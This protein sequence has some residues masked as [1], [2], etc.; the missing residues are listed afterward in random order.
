MSTTHFRIYDMMEEN[1][2]KIVDLDSLYKISCK[3]IWFFSDKVGQVNFEIHLRVTGDIAFNIFEIEWIDN[4]YTVCHARNSSQGRNNC[5]DHITIGRPLENVGTWRGSF[6]PS[7]MYHWYLAHL[8][9]LLWGDRWNYWIKW[10]QLFSGITCLKMPP[11]FSFIT[12]ALCFPC[13]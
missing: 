6:E 11:Y 1:D 13:R 7:V 12:I 4:I 3:N 10:Y 8:P 5:A 9:P 2:S